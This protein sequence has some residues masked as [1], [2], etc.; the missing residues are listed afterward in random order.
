MNTRYWREKKRVNQGPVTCM[1]NISCGARSMMTPD[2]IQWSL[3]SIED[4]SNNYQINGL[5]IKM[6][7]NILELFILRVFLP[8]FFYNFLSNSSVVPPVARHS[9]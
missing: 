5:K 3:I 2:L 6:C 1:F 7:K 4:R 9:V 8:T